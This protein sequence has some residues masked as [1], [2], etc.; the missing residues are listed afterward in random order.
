MPPARTALKKMRWSVPL[1]TAMCL[2]AMVLPARM[3][4]AA[5]V[6][7]KS[8]TLPGYVLGVV[9]RGRAVLLGRHNPH[10][11]FQL[12]IGLQLRQRTALRRF[13]QSLDNPASS[14]YHHFLTQQQ[15]NQQF[16][17]TMNQERAVERWLQLGGLTVMHTYPN[18]LIVDA[19]GTV[20]QIERLLHLAI[21][22]YRL[23]ARGKVQTFFAPATNPTVPASVS[24]IVQSIIGLDSY[25][26]IHAFQNGTAHGAVPYYPQDF[27]NAYNVNP[28]WNAGY[29]GSGQRIGITLWSRPPSDSTLQHFASVTGATVATLANGRLKVIPVDGGSK[30]ADDVEAA[31]DIEYT[32]GL[33]PGATIDYYE[34]PTDSSGKA[35]DQGLEDALNLAGTDSN[36]NQ[37]ISSSWGGCEGSSTDDPFTRATS[38]IFQANAATGHDYFFASGDNGSWC[39][40]DGS[41]AGQDPYPNYPA[42]SPYVI[43]VGGTRFNGT[44]GNRWPGESGWAY[45]AHCG[46]G[47]PLGSGGGYSALFARPSWQQGNGLAGNGQRGYPD[48]A[49]DADPQTGAY[50]CFGAKATCHQTGGTS[51]AA[52]LWAG[53]TALLNNY[54]AGQ[55]KSVGFLA[56]ALYRLAT[57]KPPYAAFHDVTVGTNGAYEATQ[58][59]DEVT[60]WG[61]ANLYNLARDLAAMPTATS[62]R[63]AQSGSVLLQAKG[64][65]SRR[66]ASFTAPASWTL[67][68]NYNCAN[69]GN[70]SAF[71]VAVQEANGQPSANGNVVQRGKRG[72]GTKQ[73]QQAGTFSLQITTQCTWQ[74]TAKQ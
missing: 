32:S 72:S 10:A 45:C 70:A 42:S 2:L 35:T 68:W 22:D 56:P 47:N 29:T 21:N 5:A 73:Y 6:G 34:A 71:I 52:P 26:R 25:P 3:P 17:P 44:I 38:N 65:G 67:Q 27:A 24:A 49:A 66:T 55:G 12:A 7:P 18:H 57:K 69:V 63:P 9:A 40:P 15:A 28:L 58:N 60:G 1:V 53:M 20:A 50:V 41:S 39:D 31:M 14:D 46:N 37:Q 36:K 30:A 54:L 4:A 33:A 74:V 11:S 23:T 64:T 8:R 19:R 16:N 51:L 43:S 48:I 13:L 59:W 62:T 61:S